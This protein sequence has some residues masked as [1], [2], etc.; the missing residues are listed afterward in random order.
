M[1]TIHLLLVGLLAMTGFALTSGCGDTIDETPGGDADG[2]ADGDTDGDSDT[3]FEPDLSNCE[4]GPTCAS[5][6]EAGREAD[7]IADFGWEDPNLGFTNQAGYPDNYNIGYVGFYGYND[8][9]EGAVQIPKPNYFASEP[10]AEITS[11]DPNNESAL[12]F[13]A[14]GFEGWG[15]GVGLDW[16]GPENPDCA[17]EGALDCL[18]LRIDDDHTPLAIAEADEACQ[19]DG[20]VDE[21]K[22]NCFKYGKN[23]NEPKDLTGYAG[24]GFWT[25]ATNKNLKDKLKVAFPI[26][27]SMRFYSEYYGEELGY[28]GVYCDE[29]DGRDGTKCYND[30]TTTV[31]LPIT[32]DDDVNTWIYHEILF[33]NV[34]YSTIFGVQPGEDVDPSYENF[35]KTQSMGIKFQVDTWQALMPDADFYID[36][37]TLL[38]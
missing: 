14:T 32:G 9:T 5:V 38:K 18:Q 11:C 19:T 20:E 15:A 1:K 6:A 26:P 28:G 3:D 25:L 29:D 34:E 21:Q 27:L 30:Y 16:G 10:S 22:I 23:I 13:Y 24:I 12:H 36:D 33:G 8:V 31:D 17:V 7:C 35:P 2:D 4:D 37:V